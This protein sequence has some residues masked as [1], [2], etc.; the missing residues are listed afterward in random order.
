MK[1]KLLYKAALALC[2]ALLPLCAWSQNDIRA[3]FTYDGKADI[4]DVTFL[5]HYILT[6]EWDDV[7]EVETRT[8]TVNGTPFVMVHVEG[9]SF[10]IDDATYNVPGF[11]IGQTEVTNIQWAA[12][13]GSD[14]GRGSTL[15]AYI[16]HPKY[17]VT[18][19]EWRDF[20]TTLNGLT[21]L[22]FRLPR[23]SEWRFAAHG[24]NRTQGFTYPGSDNHAKVAWSSEITP[25][26]VPQPVAT[27][28]CNELALYDMGGNV[29]EFCSNNAGDVFYTCGGSFRDTGDQC[30]YTKTTNYASGMWNMRYEHLGLRLAL[31]EDAFPADE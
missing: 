26:M 9:G 6:G 7:P 25:N 13:T 10:T 2:A 5:I 24:G 8:V 1:T 19:N 11:W 14:K 28:K 18:F 12:V 22:E 17:N 16:G 23:L 15:S 20:I 3:D 30:V 31:P 21:G 29:A 4:S 27:L